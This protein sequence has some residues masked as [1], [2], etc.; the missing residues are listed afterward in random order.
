MPRSVLTFGFVLSC[1]FFSIAGCG[2]KSY[3]T[4]VKVTGKVNFAGAPAKGMNIIFQAKGDLPADKRT[5]QATVKDDGS[6][7][8][9]SV[10]P[11]EYDVIL[12]G[13]AS[14]KTEMMAAVPSDTAPVDV[15]GRPVTHTA[16]VPTDK[17][18]F[19]FEF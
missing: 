17:N 5:A 18:E 14:N 1:L 9:S 12:Q 10:Y 6:Y 8:L 2:G 11:A 4:P 19:N 15:E 16:K 7:E 13:A 3:G